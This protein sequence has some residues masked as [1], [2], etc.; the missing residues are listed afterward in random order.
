[1]LWFPCFLNRN[2]CDTKW[3]KED[4][5]LIYYWTAT[6]SRTFLSFQDQLQ[7]RSLLNVALHNKWLRF[8]FDSYFEISLHKNN[9][10]NLI[11]TCIIDFTLV[12]LT[13]AHFN[14]LVQIHS[15]VMWKIGVLKT[16]TKYL[17][18]S[19]KEMIV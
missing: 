18:I 9:L 12:L 7:Q 6:V 1:M 13:E 17:K 10:F 2:I 8:L 11:S 5:L 19:V 16:S 15:E 14:R 4:I 3:V